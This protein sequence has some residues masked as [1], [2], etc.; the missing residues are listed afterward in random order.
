MASI[1][2][3]PESKYW[4]ACYTGPDGRRMKR[5]T[6]TT[7]RRQATKL[8]FKYEEAAAKKLTKKAA[9]Q[10]IGDIYELVSGEKLPGQ[11]AR[12]FLTEWPILKNPLSLRAHGAGTTT[13]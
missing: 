5:S 13:K 10:V 6:K 12:L 3:H 4:V 11:T 7:N 9:R 2:K 8:A 1:W